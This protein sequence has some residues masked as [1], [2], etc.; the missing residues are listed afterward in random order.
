[1]PTEPDHAKT[2]FLRAIERQSPENWEAY[3]DEACGNDAPLRSRVEQLLAAHE[4]L[5]S[6]RDEAPAIARTIDAERLGAEGLP[7]RKLPAS[8]WAW[9]SA[10]I[11]ARKPASGPHA[12]SRYTARSAGARCSRAWQ[13]MVMT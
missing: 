9:S 3:L 2:I 4:E 11:R 13:K 1:M 6:F 8:P 5:G 12:S 10:S 7:L